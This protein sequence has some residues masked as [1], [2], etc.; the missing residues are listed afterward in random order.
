MRLLSTL[1]LIPF[2]SLLCSLALATPEIQSW[3]TPNGAR[4]LFVETHDLPMVDIRVVFDAG[5]ARDGEHPGL[6]KLTNA[7]LDQGAGGLNADQI[8]VGFER[9]GAE[10][11]GG[12]ER[13]MGWLT[14]RSLSDQK[15]LQPALVLFE[16]VLT[17]PDFPRAD[18][19]RERERMIVAARYRGQK[20]ASIASENYYKL[21]YRSH[22]YAS[23]PGGDEESLAALKR[24]QLKAFYRQYY[25]AG[26]AVVAVVGD[27]DARQ[28]RM[29][30]DELMSG[31]PAGGH[32][33]ALPEVSPLEKSQERFIPHPSTQSHV[34]I[35][36]PGVYRGDPDYF[37][38]YVGNFI[39]GGSGLVSRISEEVREKRGLSYSAYSY[40]SPM[41]RR[42]PFTMGLQTKNEKRDEAITVLRETLQDY[43]D[44]GPTEKE[45]IAAKKNITGGF[46]IRVSSNSKIVE[47]LAMIGFYNLPLDYLE[48]FNP[49]IESVTR[50]QIIDAFRRRVDPQRMVSVIVGGQ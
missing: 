32:A 36:A 15:L 21:L 44:K 10:L 22:P 49:A 7:L 13:D 30:V 29:I 42:G 27:L 37:P 34:L 9:L 23:I 48:Q 25:V 17:R 40:F 28:A 16:K 3:K 1:L 8:A 38:L 19:R 11:G 47:Y 26:N 18:F 50:E 2:A 5:A 14:F 20:P 43:L 41:A 35:G 45:L 39:L 24:E 6:A 12:S 4:V 46:P 33:P 31:L